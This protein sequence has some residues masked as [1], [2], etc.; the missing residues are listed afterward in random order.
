MSVFSNCVQCGKP[1]E[2]PDEQSRDMAMQFCIGCRMENVRRG[3]RPDGKSSDPE[4]VQL[5]RCCYE[6]CDRDW[7]V[8]AE[9]RESENNV[10]YCEFHFGY[11]FRTLCL[12]F[13]NEDD[14]LKL[15][16]RGQSSDLKG[17]FDDKKGVETRLYS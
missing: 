9:V 12:E 8:S 5:E 1:I 7:T 14:I 15:G 3:L 16:F 11:M 4:P 2:F 6:G 17:I 13:T 10:L